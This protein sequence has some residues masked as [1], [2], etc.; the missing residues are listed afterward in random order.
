[1]TQPAEDDLIALAQAGD[2][3]ALRR[4]LLLHHDAL[5]AV[6]DRKIP[7]DL[8]STLA[9]EDVCQEAYILAVR[10]L[11]MFE[12]RGP[13]SFFNWLLTIAERKLIDAVR[14][15]R[16]A[17]RGGG[18][19]ALDLSAP[20]DATSVVALLEQVAVHEHTPS[21]SA[22][23]HELTAAVQTALA[24]LEEDYRTSIRCRYIEGLSVAETA[25]RMG[26]SPGAVRKLCSR[27]LLRLAESLGDVSRFFSRDG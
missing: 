8:R 22:A 14:K 5:C 20:V 9:V 2:E 18:Q 3:L 7:P 12:S 26:R 25:E 16:A 13:D 21:R 17:K 24:E 6:V 19:R 1:M 23:D 4:L 27:G 15:Q 10:E 11:A